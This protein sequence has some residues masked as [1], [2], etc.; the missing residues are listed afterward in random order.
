MNNDILYLSQRDLK[1]NYT[2]N[3][4]VTL[5]RYYN[6]DYTLPFIDLTWVVAIKIVENVKIKGKKR[7]NMSS[8]TD[9][10]NSINDVR[11]TAKQECNKSCLD[12]VNR[13][14][15]LFKEREHLTPKHPSLV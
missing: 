10:Q 14:E 9:I 3:D 1:S 11:K 13:L 12:L 15:K 5:A 8:L 6:L 2:Q 7:A 4:L